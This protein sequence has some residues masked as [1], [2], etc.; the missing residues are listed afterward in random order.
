MKINLFNSENHSSAFTLSGAEITSETFGANYLSFDRPSVSKLGVLD[1]MG[2]NYLRF[3]GGTIAEYF[4]WHD[5]FSNVDMNGTAVVPLDKFLNDASK[6]GASISFVMTGAYVPANIIFNNQITNNTSDLNA[7]KQQVKDFVMNHLLN[8]PQGVPISTIEIGN[9]E[10]INYRTGLKLG[11]LAEAVR[12]AIDEWGGATPPKLVFPIVSAP[13]INAVGSDMD[14]NVALSKIS[15]YLDGLEKAGALDL[16]DAVQFHNKY[17]E[18]GLSG[19]L[20]Q[21]Y[22]TIEKKMG[23]L[24]K[25]YEGFVKDLESRGVKTPID[26]YDTEFNLKIAEATENTPKGLKA[27]PYFL[28]IVSE[29]QEI[30][31]EKMSAWWLT[32]NDLDHAGSLA[33][34]SNLKPAGLLYQTMNEFLPR[35]RVV[36]ENFIT[37]S[38]N[39]TIT[40]DTHMYKNVGKTVLYVSNMEGSQ[41]QFDL[42]LNNI[43]N[44]FSNFESITISIG[45]GENPT[46]GKPKA[47]GTHYTLADLGY[48]QNHIVIDLKAYETSV[49]VFYFDMKIIGTN[50]GENLISEGGN[51]TINAMGGDDVINGMGGDDILTGGSGSDTF[52]FEKS[53]GDDRIVDFQ[54]NI[55]TIHIFGNGNFDLSHL[56]SNAVQTEEGVLID[57][58]DNNSIFIGEVTISQLYDDILLS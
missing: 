21:N 23:Q 30:G 58:G 33:D 55:D 6:M 20:L 10:P 17:Q 7:F 49:L 51:D 46:S 14:V 9:E 29:M 19:D 16:I 53:S 42:N 27:I 4:N 36:D 34:N 32:R 37:Y 22:T 41:N 26:L 52:Q 8:N 11:V 2:V 35:T 50:L 45:Q 47:V 31:V 28:E 15:D 3:P 5:P 1:E 56:L 25:I 44:G 40:S 54:D 57:L 39:G 24:H 48:D 18:G 12:E 43:A 13:F 38:E